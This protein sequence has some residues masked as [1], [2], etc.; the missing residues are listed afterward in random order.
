[1]SQL[2]NSILGRSQK[3]IRKYTNHMANTPVDSLFQKF[4]KKNNSLK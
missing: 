3:V 4:V 1:M 2:L